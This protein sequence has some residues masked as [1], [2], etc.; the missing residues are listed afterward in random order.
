MTTTRT[1]IKPVPDL[2][3]FKYKVLN[4]L[5]KFSTFCFF[6]SNNYSSW[7]QG[8]DCLAAGGIKRDFS[9]EPG[10]A[11]EDF[12]NFQ[13]A[14]PH[15]SWLFGH[16]SYELKN[17]IYQLNPTDKEDPLGFPGLYFFEPEV[18][19]IIKNAELT[20]VADDPGRIYL[21]IETAVPASSL[22]KNK[23]DISG[24]V[25]QDEYLEV[26]GKLK[27]HIHRGDCYEI[28]YCMEFFQ[29]GSVID[30]AYVF[31]QLQEVSPNPFSV[32]YRSGDKWLICASPERFLR[33][34][35]A[36]LLSQPIKG[37]APRYPGN[38]MRDS[39]AKEE[40]FNSQKDRSENVMVVDLVRNDLSR[41]CKTGTVTVDELYGIY[42]FPQ[43]HQMISTV[44]GELDPCKNF[45]DIMRA[46]FPMGSMTGAPKKRVLELIDE[47][48]RTKRGIFSGAVGYI[49]PG[50]DFDI[51]V[52]IRSLMYNART[53]YLSFQAGSGITFYSDPGKEWE[54]CLLKVEAI[55]KVLSE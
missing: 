14:S 9:A 54:E 38:E 25:G 27:R 17:E 33:K 22:S 29:E 32:L 55:R 31:E 48:E 46:C 30:P 5:K 16:L 53:N 20:I 12:Q 34:K 35:G 4:W 26:I 45:A 18:L 1:I 11:L 44:R 51:N 13:D 19:V 42:S 15:R 43:V 7:G 2:N 21:E 47:Y 50:G 52:V 37:T 3:N 23:I 10:H 40:L 6:D 24:R 41:V 28:N 49:D 36:E 8:I 39:R